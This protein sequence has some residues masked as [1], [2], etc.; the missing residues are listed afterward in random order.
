MNPFAI[1][2]YLPGRRTQYV[3]Y[4]SEDMSIELG[5]GADLCPRGF[6]SDVRVRFRLVGEEWFVTPVLGE[7][8]TEEGIQIENTCAVSFPCM[9]IAGSAALVLDCALDPRVPARVIQNPRGTRA[10][11]PPPGPV[12]G[13]TL[14]RVNQRALSQPAHAVPQT[15]GATAVAFVPPQPRAFV[16]PQ[17]R[18]S[19]AQPAVAVGGRAPALG[20][21]LEP[22][23]VVHQAEEPAKRELT[24]TRMFDMK[25]LGIAQ[26]A[27][28]TQAPSAAPSA[29]ASL[30]AKIK[31]NPRVVAYA[32]LGLGL[33]GL[34]VGRLHLHILPDRFSAAQSV[35][36]AAPTASGP[37]A[38]NSA[39]ADRTHHWHS[40]APLGPGEIPNATRAGELYALGDYRAAL[41]QYRA[42]S[43]QPQAEPVFGL[44]AHALEQRLAHLGKP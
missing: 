27:E 44:I 18:V 19:G 31:G 39:G 25:Q 4:P 42:L 12:P 1:K 8:R 34:Q 15:H 40:E 9:L 3:L 2:C 10:S 30:V 36:T 14:P 5:A 13:K 28:E 38:A 37:E 26:N 35:A 22:S 17:P 11:A 41:R 43:Q 23:I 33:M 24:E 7:L 32:V 16:P 20:P 6:D 21:L 29:V